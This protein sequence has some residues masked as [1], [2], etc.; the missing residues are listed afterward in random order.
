MTIPLDHLR[1]ERDKTLPGGHV[2]RPVDEGTRAELEHFLGGPVSP[3]YLDCL[4]EH[5]GTTL[6]NVALPCPTSEKADPLRDRPYDV[7]NLYLFGNYAPNS[8]G[9]LHTRSIDYALTGYRHSIPAGMLPLGEHIDY[10]FLHYS[11]RPES[12]G[13][14]F[15]YCPEDLPYYNA[16]DPECAGQEPPDP[17]VACQEVAPDLE[18]F[19]KNLRSFSEDE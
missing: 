13:R 12:Y 4:A 14:L 9:K 11:C 6:F 10:R 1:W 17:F 15:L 5:G 7:W 19:F 16:Y 2:L 18:T 8:G 3:K